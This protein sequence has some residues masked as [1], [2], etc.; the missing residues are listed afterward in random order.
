MKLLKN[1]TLVVL[2]F[3]LYPLVFVPV[4]FT[5]F[6]SLLNWWVHVYEHYLRWVGIQ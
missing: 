2:G 3:V 5:F 4:M 6:P 1:L